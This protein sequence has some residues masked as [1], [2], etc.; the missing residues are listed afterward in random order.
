M[1]GTQIGGKVGDRGCV[2]IVPISVSIHARRHL[3]IA[4]KSGPV[5]WGTGYTSAYAKD[6]A[7]GLPS[8]PGSIRCTAAG[9]T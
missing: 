3:D 4:L 7:A 2:S 1:D 6:I 9:S 5:P 8:E